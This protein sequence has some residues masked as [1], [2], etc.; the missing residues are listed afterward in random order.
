MNE[1]EGAM[2]CRAWGD[3]AW[4]RQG[5]PQP[6]GQAVATQDP[7]TLTVYVR[8][9]YMNGEVLEWRMLCMERVICPKVSARRP[10][11]FGPVPYHQI[12]DRGAKPVDKRPLA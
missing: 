9:Q 7:I 8:Q 1:A 5:N 10:L 12:L 6:R 2:I 3:E 11:R 4:K